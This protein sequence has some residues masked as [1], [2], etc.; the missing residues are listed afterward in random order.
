MHDWIRVSGKRPLNR[1]LE[2]GTLRTAYVD[3]SAPLP[4]H[5]LV[6]AEDIASHFGDS[7]EI[8][9]RKGQRNGSASDKRPPDL[10]PLSLFAGWLM[11]AEGGRHFAAK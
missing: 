1:I 2:A 8:R 6:V 5:V 3:M 9:R 4:E 10:H 11:L 7:Q